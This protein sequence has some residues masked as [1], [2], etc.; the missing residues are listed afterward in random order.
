MHQVGFSSHDLLSYCTL[1][2]FYKY[3]ENVTRIYKIEVF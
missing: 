1:F 2:L 3:Q